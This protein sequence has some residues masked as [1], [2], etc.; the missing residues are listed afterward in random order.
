MDLRPLEDDASLHRD[1]VLLLKCSKSVNWVIKTHSVTGKLDVLV[2]WLHGNR[3]T[4]S[5]LRCVFSFLPS[6]TP[7]LRFDIVLSHITVNYKS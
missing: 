1:V 7:P 5:T 4:L 2:S 3:Q 6:R